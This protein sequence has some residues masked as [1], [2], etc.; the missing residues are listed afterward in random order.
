L[1]IGS[2]AVTGPNAAEFA[3]VNNCG[4]SL[5]VGASCAINV[6]FTATVAGAP[7][8]AMVVVS[9][10]AAGGGQSIAAYGVA[11]KK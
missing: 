8:V 4:S 5:A 3:Q 7:Q 1:T 6:T 9:D 11:S 10:N 2:I